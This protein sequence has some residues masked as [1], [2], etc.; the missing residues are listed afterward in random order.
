MAQCPGWPQYIHRLLSQHLF[1]SSL[2]MGPRFQDQPAV[3]RSIGPG[4]VPVEVDAEWGV[5]GEVC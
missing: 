1:F 4:A 5:T 2:S 3:V